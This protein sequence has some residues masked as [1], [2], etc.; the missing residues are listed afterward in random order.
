MSEKRLLLIDGNS[1]TYKAFFALINQ[2]NSFVNNEGIHTNAV[3]GFNNMLN[4]MLDKFKPTNVLVAFDAG[5]TTFRTE[6]YAD[7]K[8]GRDKTPDELREQFDYVKELLKNRGIKYYQLDNYEADD[9]IG[10]LSK[11]ADQLGFET[12]IVTGD[13]DLTQLCSDKTTVSISNRGVSG[14]VRYDTDYVKETMGITPEQIIDWKAL[15]GDSSDNYSGV[16]GVG[17]KT[18]LK[19]VTQFGSVE[20]LYEHLDEV[21]GKKLLEHLTEDKENAFLAKKLATINRNAPIEIT[22]D[23]TV[24][25]GDHIKELINFYREMNF[26]KFLSEMSADQVET[27]DKV[28]FVELNSDNVNDID[29]KDGSNVS[30]YLGMDGDNYHTADYIGFALKIDETNYISRNIELL[31][32]DNLKALLESNKISKNV[33]DGKRTYVGLNRLG[34]KLNNVDFDLLLASYLLD[35]NDNSYDLGKVANRHDYFDVQSD[36]D[37]YGKGAKRA[38]PDDDILFDHFARKV[39]AINSLKDKLFDELKENNQVD[40]YRDVE[41]PLSFVLARMEIA[42]VVINKDILISMKSK[43]S[44]KLLEIKQSIYND[45]GEE[46]NI[47]SPKQLG[48]ILFDKMQLP[49][50]K[51]TKTG[52]STAVGVLEQLAPDY[53]IVEKVLEYRKYSKILSTYVEGLLSDIHVDNKVHTRY[54]QTL[55]Q[56]GRLSSVDPNLQNIPVRTEEGRKI[57]QAFIPSESNWQ[58]FSSDYSQIELRVLASIS[59]DKNMQDEFIHN[60]DIHASTARRIFGLSDNSEVTPEY[61]RQAKAVNFGIVYGISDFGLSK[62]TG[63][64]RNDAKEFIEKYF[65]EYPGVKKY[66]EDSVNSAREKGYVETILH[67]RRYLPD[68]N[69]KN[70]NLRSFAER[71][72]MNSPIQGSAAD[73]IKIAMIKME[74][75]LEKRNLKA[76][77][78][79][80]VHD[81][82]IFEAPSEEIEI[83]EELVPKVMDSA[84]K[85]NV[86]LNVKSHYGNSWYSLK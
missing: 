71:T 2:V 45:A 64:S 60:D 31:M 24:Y 82:L 79:L 55:T 48:E 34:I 19:L 56:T 30:F 62:N 13:N 61:R 8:S 49:V 86:P 26:R 6:M 57:R 66:M 74:Q 84:V 65:A 36:E 35:T 22:V 75:E 25:D 68:I 44:E 58:I 46:F 15:K 81:E 80:Q 85:L 67:R 51:K 39:N 42:G 11:E 29:V 41:L 12:T 50:V 7:Y 38:I 76:K 28:D 70:F 40:L 63:I 5:K 43:I 21:S 9:I 83:L 27:M 69:A 1:I 20:N 37:V 18:A 3:F 52:Y 77:M 54:L 23:D 73:I 72:A 33:F 47:A 78:L 4:I 14:V 10:T 53:P 17:D 59:G 16:T 32:D